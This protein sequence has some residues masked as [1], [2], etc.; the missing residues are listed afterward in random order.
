LSTTLLA[1][2]YA[3]VQT[4]D[5]GHSSTPSDLFEVWIEG[6]NVEFLYSR[7]GQLDGDLT[8]EIKQR[9]YTAIEEEISEEASRVYGPF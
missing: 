8:E 3:A 5:N 6:K 4:F 9:I 7:Q 1:A 2:L